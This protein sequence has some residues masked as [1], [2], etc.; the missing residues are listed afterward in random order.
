MK[1]RYVAW[2]FLASF[3]SRYTTAAPVVESAYQI[4]AVVGKAAITS[5]QFEKRLLQIKNQLM[6]RKT[7]IPAE[8]VLRDIVLEQ[9]INEE[10]V[11]QHA[12]NRGVKISDQEVQAT[13]R[14]IAKQRNT[15]LDVVEQE[16]IKQYGNKE[17]AY[18][19][20]ERVII[21]NSFQNQV[22]NQRI[23]VT[24]QDVGEAMKTKN[25]QYF[26]DHY[27]LEQTLFVLPST[28][29]QEKIKVLEN[30]IKQAVQA[31]QAGQDLA[32]ATQALKAQAVAIHVNKLN[33]MPAY[34]LMSPLSEVVSQ[35]SV[36]GYT[37]L[38]PSPDGFIVF[39]LVG[40]K[41]DSADKAEVKQYHVAHILLKTHDKT[42]DKDCLE[43]IQQLKDRLLK[44]EDFSELAKEYSEDT[45]RQEGGDIGWIDLGQTVAPFEAAFTQLALNAVSEPVRTEFGWH[46]I[47]VIGIRTYNAH[48]Q[49]FKKVM[50]QKLIQQNAEAVLTDHVRQ[51]REATYVEKRPIN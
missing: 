13:L 22:I 33:W 50:Q 41:Q 7:K 45:S 43:K 32:T 3:L 2:I 29:D 9:L 28:T 49:D 31:L 8:A 10:V 44:G 46:L 12:Q 21:M 26:N 25:A 14:N 40:K 35:L 36:G 19:A 16:L 15:T 20:L 6:T 27:L 17:S 34:A 38:M 39:E 30:Q 51:L 18:E 23:Q 5:L 24:D 42:T 37:D 1:L 47:K 4:V 48:Y 11:I